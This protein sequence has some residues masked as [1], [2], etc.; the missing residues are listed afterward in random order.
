MRIG[1]VAQVAGVNPKTIRYYESIG[2]L[3][4]PARMGSG[5]RNY[6]E[7]FY[8]RLSFIRTARRLGVTLDEVKEILSFSERGET[9]CAYVLGVLDAQLE[10]IDRRI[11]ELE[12]LREQLT[13]ITSEADRIPPGDISGTCR[14]IEHVRHQTDDAKNSWDR[15]RLAVR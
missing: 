9:P 3:A 1:E 15:R 4:A 14:L 5:Y 10:G 12:L 11:E 13:E 2:V 7:S 6:D 8:D